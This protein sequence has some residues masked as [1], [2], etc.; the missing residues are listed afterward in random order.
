MSAG[1]DSARLHPRTE[2]TRQH[3]TDRS[4][5]VYRNQCCYRLIHEHLEIIPSDGISYVVFAPRYFFQRLLRH[6]IWLRSHVGSH[7]YDNQIDLLPDQWKIEISIIY[8]SNICL[9]NA[10]AVYDCFDPCP[11]HIIN[12]FNCTSITAQIVMCGPIPS[13]D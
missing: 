2:G 1:V 12:H 4:F 13:Q 7:V 5:A 11:S 9:S 10:S 8:V 6:D 3:A